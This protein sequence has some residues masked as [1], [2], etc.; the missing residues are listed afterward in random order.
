MEKRDKY[1]ENHERKRA[2]TRKRRQKDQGVHGA[3]GEG[4][5]RIRSARTRSAWISGGRR[6]EPQ[7][8]Q[9]RGR[10][11]KAAARSAP[12]LGGRKTVGKGRRARDG[13]QGAM[14]KGRWAR[15]EGKGMMGVG[16]WARIHERG[17]GGG[18]TGGQQERVG[19]ERWVWE[20]G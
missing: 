11:H 3:P 2:G 16:R 20:G 5:G 8:K 10:A 14:G 7:G 13:G 15:H 12:A 6:A 19:K 18:E 9:H 4:S 17:E 1:E